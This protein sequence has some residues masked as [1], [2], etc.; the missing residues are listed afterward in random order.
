MTAECDMA[1]EN[2]VESPVRAGRSVPTPPLTPPP[3]LY[4]VVQGTAVFL[5][6]SMSAAG[7]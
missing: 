6:L 3:P 1:G 7:F 4:V 2:R 5:G